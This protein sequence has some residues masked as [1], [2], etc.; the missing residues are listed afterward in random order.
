[1]VLKIKEMLN[2]QFKRFKEVHDGKEFAEVLGHYF[3]DGEKVIDELSL[4]L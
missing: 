2:D 1:M 3:V 4:L